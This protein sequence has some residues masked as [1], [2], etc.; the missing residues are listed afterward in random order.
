MPPEPRLRHILL[1][2]DAV[3]PSPSAISFAV[4]LAVRFEAELQ[5]MLLIQAGLGRAA[6]LPFATE[7]SLLAGLERRL[8][9]PLMRRS[10]ES[11]TER[12]RVTVAQ[13]ADPAQVRWSLQSVEWSDWEGLL[14]QPM[15]GRLFV[16]GRAG[17]HVTVHRRAHPPAKPGV[18]VVYDESPSGRAALDIALALDPEP[19][20]LPVHTAGMTG[21]ASPETGVD[22]L[23]NCLT[24]LRPQTLILPAVWYAARAT[25]LQPVLTRSECNL[26]LV[27]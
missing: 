18:C 24:R 7:I 20:R 26:L 17:D 1:G 6:A 21:D 22:R 14:V 10:L 9:A 4:A 23:A 19:A 15:E 12:V 16:L 11:L 5:T 3:G 8:S 2:L 27:S 13:L 25:T